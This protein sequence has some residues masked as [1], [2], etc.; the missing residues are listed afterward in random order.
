MQ[1]YGI[2]FRKGTFSR[3]V[4]SKSALNVFLQSF[5][6]ALF[7]SRTHTRARTHA[8]CITQK[9]DENKCICVRDNRR[10]QGVIADCGLP[11][12]IED[13]PVY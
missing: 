1:A 9:R 11:D 13:S 10:C 6:N 12:S 8:P 2:E 4:R 7:K 5:F 3:D